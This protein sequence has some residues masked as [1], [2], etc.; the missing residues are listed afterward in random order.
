[1]GLT[2]KKLGTLT[3][4]HVTLSFEFGTGGSNACPSTEEIQDRFGA[5]H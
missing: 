4:V 2:I 5:A 1:L 3:E